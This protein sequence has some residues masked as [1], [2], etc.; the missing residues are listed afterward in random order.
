M[1]LARL[2]LLVIIGVS[3]AALGEPLLSNGVIARVNEAIITKKDLNN[4]VAPDIDFLQRQYSSDVSVFNQKLQALGERHLKE[5][6]EEQLILH[7]FTT[8]GFV[9]PESYIEDLVSKDIKTYG[10]RL[11]LTKTLQAQ[12]LTFERYRERV[13]KNA[14]IREMRRQNVPQD[15]LISPHKIELH[16]LGNRDKFKVEDQVK[17]RMIVIPNRFD[18]QGVSSKTMAGEIV[19]KLK[20][21]VPFAELAR[22]Y[23]QS[24]QSSEGGD[25]GWVERSV[26][27]SDLAEQAFALKPGELSDVISASDGSYI[28]LVEGFRAA[29]IK[30]LTE[31]REEIETTLK[32]EERDR[33]HEKWIK[34]LE[35]KSLIRYY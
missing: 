14:V 31:V 9:L 8:A 17:M 3:P 26:L 32:D 20:E 7:E 23:S 30:S 12:G 13:R 2:F 34:K 5:L 19:A 11:I 16:Y 29:H 28:M 6:V 10:D 25:W 24:S 4:R 1:N 18:A 27:R 35:E 15:P 21:G 33:L 22:I